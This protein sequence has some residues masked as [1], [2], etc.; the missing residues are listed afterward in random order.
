MGSELIE[1]LRVWFESGQN[2]REVG[3]RMHLAPRTIAYR[4]ERIERLLGD[5]LSG[6]GGMRLAAALLALD[7]LRGVERP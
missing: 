7:V 1:T 3:R 6:H 5:G 2:L 4:M